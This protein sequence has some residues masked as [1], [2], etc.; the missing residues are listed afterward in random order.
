MSREILKKY[1]S[2]IAFALIAVAFFVIAITSH[3]FTRNALR[4]ASA[5]EI[6]L[7]QKLNRLDRYVEQAMAPDTTGW[8]TLG[9]LPEDMVIYKYMY[10]TLQSWRN[11]FIITND[12][13][14]SPYFADQR[15]SR[16]EY[17]LNPPLAQIGE[18]WSFVNIGPKWYVA[19]TVKDG[20]CDVVAALEVCSMDAE[21]FSASPNE[22]LLIPEFYSI[23]PLQGYDGVEVCYEGK[24]IFLMANSSPDTTHLFANTPFRWLG[25]AFMVISLLLYV[26]KRRKLSAYL[27]SSVFFILFFI[28]AR[29][30]GSQMTVSSQIF[31]PTIYAGG[32]IWSSFGDL[33]VLNL[34]IVCEFLAIFLSRDAI[35][36]W[37]SKGKSKC[38]MAGV[39]AVLALLFVA[40]F[41]YIIV[42][43]VD[44][45]NNSTITFEIQWFKDGLQYTIMALVVYSLLFSSLLLLLKV[46][47]GP[48]EFFTGKSMKLLNTISITAVAAVVAIVL[49][50]F[51][52]FLGFRKEESRVNVWANR[53]AVDRDLGLELHLRSIEQAIMMDEVIGVLTSVDGTTGMIANRLRETYLMR[54]VND[55]DIQVSTCAINDIDCMVLFN[56]KLMGGTP[57]ADVT[58]FV[59]QYSANGHSSY[60][61]LFTYEKT[62]GDITRMLVEIGSKAAREDSGYYSVFTGLNSPGSVEIPEE[63]SYAKYLSSRL[64]SYRGT[65]AYPTVVT[66]TY[67]KYLLESKRHYRANGFVHF[68]NKVDTEEIIV[69]SRPKKT[70]LQLFSSLLSIF[71]VVVVV[72]LPLT[73]QRRRRKIESK[74]TFRRRISLV[75]MG[76]ICIALV[77]LASISIKFVFDRNKADTNDMMSAKISTL[78]T[79]VESLVQDTPDYTALMSQEFRNSLLSIAANTRSDVNL[80]TPS[81]RLFVTTV[82]DVFDRDILSTRIPDLAYNEI[83]NGHQRLFMDKESIDGNSYFSLYAPVFNRNDEMVAIVSTP[84]SSGSSLMKE[85]LPHAVLLIILV[86]TLLAAFS[87]ISTGVVNAVFAP[88]TEVSRKMKGAAV[89]GLETID[90]PHDDEISELIASYNRMVVDLEES[91]RKMAENERD[92][93]WSEMARQ[94]AHEIKNPL[95]PMKLAIQRLIRFKEKGDPKWIERFD[96]LTKVI[97]EQID[98]LT[99]TANDFSSFAK[100]YTEDPVEFDLDKMLQ[101][102]LLIF[103][104]KEN[105]KLTYIGMPDAIIVAPRPQLIRV[106]VN[107]ITNSIQAV[108]ID[109]KEC[110][111]RGEEV[112][113]GM[114]NVLLR[115]SSKDGYY[116]VVVED[117]GPGVAEENKDKLFTPKF[118]TKSAGSGLGLAMSRNIVD[119]CGG[120]ISYMRSITLGGAAFLVRLPMKS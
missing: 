31:S 68:I 26:S 35:Y 85:A 67:E 52:A 97:L 13:I 47:A 9:E 116:D 78:Q 112:R 60:V 24:P 56:R 91:T 33:M 15:L 6:R 45:I 11:E 84:Y 39:W 108:E 106:V 62:N 51:S 37:A 5:T 8:M 119:K 79:M 72:M 90:Y 113:M 20:S 50:C 101:E 114:V 98:N 81:G 4:V 88:L 87:A 71:A 7:G 10:D 28:L 23:C 118:T 96:D 36:A 95:T 92:M 105:V 17:G 1:A 120:E 46:M 40:A 77:T 94:V 29:F 82:P 19:K 103:D 22:S 75:L 89:D 69:V 74:N 34:L 54:Y 65:Y 48:F 25:L 30:W 104:N 41:A 66:D 102:Q 53:L 107:L 16:T 43:I 12:A 115:K 80:Y 93:A 38:R 21:G 111:E 100:L 64:V 32:Q 61:G 117:N 18:E 86:L 27:C 110:E 14:R 2:S 73:L 99:E 63:Y 76:T 55:Y 44:L 42:S 58:N 57:I 49:F 59:C 109:Q 70:A 3:S 83:V